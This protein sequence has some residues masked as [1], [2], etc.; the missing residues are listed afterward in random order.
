MTLF[1]AHMGK[2]FSYWKASAK[3]LLQKEIIQSSSSLGETPSSSLYVHILRNVFLA[4]VAW[5]LF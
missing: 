2:T 5:I 1:V 4:Q 3:Q